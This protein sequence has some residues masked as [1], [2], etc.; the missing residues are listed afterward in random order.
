MSFIHNHKARSESDDGFTLIELLIVI[1]ILGILAGIVTFGV[2]TFR[3]DAQ[4]S[5]TATNAKMVSTAQTA[6]V[7]KNGGVASSVTVPT[8]VSAGYLESAPAAC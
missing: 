2:A 5:C 4:A 7:A 8:L 3:G 6:Y 1:V